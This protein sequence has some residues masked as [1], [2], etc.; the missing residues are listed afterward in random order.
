MT[1]RMKLTEREREL[2]EAFR[3]ERAIYNSALADAMLALEKVDV[4]GG[5]PG[6]YQSL[7]AE[8][9]KLRKED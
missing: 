9:L 4:P 6:N 1:T 2:V 8:I 5:R 7:Q 3:T